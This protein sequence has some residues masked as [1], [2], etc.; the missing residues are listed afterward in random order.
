[1]AIDSF[2]PNSLVSSAPA[3]PEGRNAMSERG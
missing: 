3:E 1:M 2:D